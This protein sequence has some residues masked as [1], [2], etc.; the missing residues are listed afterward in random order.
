[1]GV[2][3]V[4]CV[5][6]DGGVCTAFAYAWVTLHSLST[7]ELPHALTRLPNGPAHRRWYAI[8]GTRL[9]RPTCARRG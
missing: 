5:G 6:G 7:T 3:Y 2:D 9:A 1:M 4:S 8:R